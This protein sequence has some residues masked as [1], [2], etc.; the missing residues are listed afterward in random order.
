MCKM[1]TWY[2]NMT[3]SVFYIKKI[4]ECSKNKQLKK[5]NKDVA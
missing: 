3:V 2:S 4:R 1:M 5:G